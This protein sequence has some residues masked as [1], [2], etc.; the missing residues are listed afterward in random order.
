MYN[1]TVYNLTNISYCGAFVYIL[2]QMHFVV[3]AFC[4][5]YISEYDAFCSV[6]YIAYYDLFCSGYILQWMHFASM[7][8]FVVDTCSGTLDCI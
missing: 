3:H 2:L 4:G 1:V 7:M 6:H 5:R 8:Y